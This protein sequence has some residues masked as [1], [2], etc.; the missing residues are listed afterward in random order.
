LP[1]GEARRVNAR[2]E[3]WADADGRNHLIVP[4]NRP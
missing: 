3:T 4:I 2:G 1:P